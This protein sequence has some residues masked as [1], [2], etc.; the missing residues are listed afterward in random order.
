VQSPLVAALVVAAALAYYA[1]S[2]A[3][4]TAAAPFIAPSLLRNASYLSSSVSVL[5]QMFCLGATL[6]AVPLYL[7]R[8]LGESSSTAGA[9]VFVMPAAMTV[10]AP[11]SGYA[12]HRWGGGVPMIGGLLL[13]AAAAGALARLIHGDSAGLVP[14]AASLAIVGVG[15]G[16]VQ[17]PAAAGATE[18][19]RGAQGAGLGMFNQL[20]F[21]GSALGAAWAAT[22]LGAQP[23]YPRVFTVCA[24][25]AVLAALAVVAVRRR[26]GSGA[27]T[28]S[29]DSTS[30]L[31][32]SV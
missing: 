20:R 29:P 23:S 2:R 13:M 1:F 32:M 4:R 18:A 27:M 19:A 24:A 9:L 30:Q 14:I 3:V 15:F 28:N 7:V 8:T 31:S 25:V 12:M 21:A 22:A 6:I 26:D 10:A 17:A 5:A 16:L 11:V